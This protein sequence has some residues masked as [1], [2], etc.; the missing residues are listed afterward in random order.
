[1]VGRFRPATYVS[2]VRSL[3][4]DNRRKH[5]MAGHECPGYKTYYQWAHALARYGGIWYIA[6]F[7]RIEYHGELRSAGFAQAVVSDTDCDYLEQ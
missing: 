3:A 6:A 1:M 2:F 4:E 5:S 7:Q